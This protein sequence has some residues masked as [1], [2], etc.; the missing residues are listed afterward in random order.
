MPAYLVKSVMVSQ[1]QNL[2]TNK[3]KIVEFLQPINPFTLLAPLVKTKKRLTVM[4][5]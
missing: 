3:S 4:E 5:T 2:G 1:F